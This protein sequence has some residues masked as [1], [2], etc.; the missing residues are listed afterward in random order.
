MEYL[1]YSQQASWEPHSNF[2]SPIDL[3]VAQNLQQAFTQQPL[4]LTFMANK[5]LFKKEQA[6]GDQFL[7]GGVL[8][9]G[10]QEFQLQRLH[11]HDGS[12]HTING[13]HFDGEIHLVF[14]NTAQENLVLALLCEVAPESQEQV[15]LTQIYQEQADSSD[16]AALLPNDLSY[17]TYT[18]SL[19]TPPLQTG[20]TWVVLAQPHLISKGSKTALHTDYPDNHRELQPVNGR[21]VEFFQQ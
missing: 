2:E 19:T 21:K 18:G 5:P 16:L 4:S 13:Q 8:T 20:V 14:Q 3:T 1:D 6:N 11:L 7:A 15:P 10:A 12:E 9:I 17:Y